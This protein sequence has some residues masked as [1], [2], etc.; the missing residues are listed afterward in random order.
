MRVYSFYTVSLPAA[1][2]TRLHVL[3]HRFSYPAESF[4]H[5]ILLIR[6]NILY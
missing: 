2:V 6:V 4:G 1:A 5:P 3:P